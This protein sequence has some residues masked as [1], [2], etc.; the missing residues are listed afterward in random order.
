MR[1]QLAENKGEEER[2]GEGSE[3][4][5]REWRGRK[6]VRRKEDQDKGRVH[7]FGP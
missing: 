5:G 2:D 6:G 1:W 4:G 3:E 7:E